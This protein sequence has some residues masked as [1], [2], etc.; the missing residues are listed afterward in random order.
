MS[1]ASPLVLHGVARPMFSDLVAQKRMDRIE[2][3][4]IVRLDPHGATSRQILIAVRDLLAVVLHFDNSRRNFPMC[5]KR[6][7]EMTPREAA[8]APLKM[9]ADRRNRLLVSLVLDRD[10]DRPA[11]RGQPEV[12][13]GGVLV[14]PHRVGAAVRSEERRV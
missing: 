13:H 12:M 2:R 4:G 6:L 3:S 14:E 10:L 9:A 5:L 7:V 8:R 1:I 11:S